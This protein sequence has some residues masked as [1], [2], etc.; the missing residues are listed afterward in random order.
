MAY[1]APIGIRVG[2]RQ[3]RSRA[4]GASSSYITGAHAV[5]VGLTHRSGRQRGVSLRHAPLTYRF[6]NGVPNQLTQRA[7]PIEV[8]SQ[9]DHDLG[10]FAQ[11]RW[12]VRGLTLTAGVRYDYFANSYP[13]AADRADAARA[14]AEHHDPRD[15]RALAITTSRRG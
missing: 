7:L 2:G 4:S 9:V 10:V 13:G 12:T 1:R 8:K 11:D 5:K 3:S 15:S 14:D 6:N